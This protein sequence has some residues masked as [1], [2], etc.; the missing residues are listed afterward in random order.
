[1]HKFDLSNAKRK[2]PVRIKSRRNI[3]QFFV[4]NFVWNLQMHEKLGVNDK[5]KIDRI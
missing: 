1:M 5:N 4:H 2:N 3:S